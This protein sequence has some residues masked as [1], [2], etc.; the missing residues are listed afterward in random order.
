MDFDFEDLRV[1][2]YFDLLE[3]IA[4]ADKHGFNRRIDGKLFFSNMRK[5][6][7]EPTKMLFPVYVLTIHEHIDGEI[8]DPHYR[9]KIIGPEINEDGIMGAILD[10]EI[11]RYET[12][13]K[14]VD[15]RTNFERWSDDM[16]KTIH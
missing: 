4:A 2:T 9:I 14:F 3:F 1:M 6:G 11:D 13:S 10:C 7:Y 16:N 5:L 8:V 12:L 15:M